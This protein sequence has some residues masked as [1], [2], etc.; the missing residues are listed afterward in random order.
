MNLR[1]TGRRMAQ[2][3]TPEMAGLAQYLSNRIQLRDS[4][5]HPGRGGSDDDRDDDPDDDDPEDDDDDDSDDDRSEDGDDDKSKKSKGKKSDSEDDDEESVPAWRHE[6]VVARMKASD[7]KNHELRAEIERLKA[8]G[9]KDED[10]KR[11]LAEA[12]ATADK[13]E[14]DNVR[15]RLKVSFLSTRVRGI[16]WA[17]PADAMALLD[18]KALDAEDGEVDPRAMRSAI[19]DLAKRKPYLLAKPV[20]TKTR[21]DSDGSDDDAGTDGGRGSRT[22][23]RPVNGRRGKPAATRSVESLQKRFRGA[24]R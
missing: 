9:I 22:S 12:K 19:R 3:V 5:G 11:E 15:L 18:F 24:F 17:D 1:F 20:T 4:D 16:E 10:V 23:A 21:D 13:R 14:S 8:D 6:K 2:C 7:R